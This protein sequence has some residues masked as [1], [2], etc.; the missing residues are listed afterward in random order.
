MNLS[1]AFL[2]NNCIYLFLTVLHCH[3]CAGFPL[4]WASEGHSLALHGLLTMGFLLLQSGS[5]RVH[6]FHQLWLQGLFALQQVG[7]SWMRDWTC[8]SCIG[9]QTLYHWVTRES[10]LPHELNLKSGRW[11]GPNCGF[12]G[13]LNRST[14]SNKSLNPSEPWLPYQ[15]NRTGSYSVCL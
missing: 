9:R 6:E 1:R 15:F 11:W 13:S 10:P 5:S 8:V 4:V 12:W 14:V 7:A 2:K 3:C